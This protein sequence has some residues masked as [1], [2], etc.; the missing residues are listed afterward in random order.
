MLTQDTLRA[1]SVEFCFEPKR[2]APLIMLR[3]LRVAP[4]ILGLVAIP[5]SARDVHLG[6][7]KVFSFEL[8]VACPF[9]QIC[10]QNLCEWH[11]LVACTTD[12]IPVLRRASA[13]HE[14]TLDRVP[15]IESFVV[16]VLAKPRARD[17]C[18]RIV[19]S[20]QCSAILQAQML[21]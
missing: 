15:S 11:R 4:N 14:A 1:V 6:M 5:R 19:R 20:H 21:P 18:K 16:D 2:K 13:K 7:N 12:N 17:S 9:P 8:K 3:I 10:A